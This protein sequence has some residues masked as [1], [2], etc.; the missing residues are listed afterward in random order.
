M[1]DTRVSSLMVTCAIVLMDQKILVVQRSESM[2]LPLKWE[3]PGGKIEADETELD[4]IKREIKEEINIEIELTKRL[5]PSQFDYSNK[6]I[7]L[8][9]FLANYVSGEIF[10]KEHKQYKLLSKNE[11]S[12][13]DW[14]EADI[15]LLN[16][17]LSL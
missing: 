2:P 13:L 14:A 17:F 5:R 11:L 16:E 6:S 9:P 1:N 7:T 4:C 10:L 8:I 15:P 3:F 12:Q